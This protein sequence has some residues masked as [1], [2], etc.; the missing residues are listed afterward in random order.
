M[1]WGNQEHEKLYPM[2]PFSFV[3][4]EALGASAP[5]RCVR[6]RN[7]ADCKK[8]EVIE[9]ISI[10]EEAEQYLIEESVKYMVS[11]KV[12]EA[13]LPFIKSP[14]EQLEGQLQQSL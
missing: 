9:R 3:E 14:E 5:Y 7:C 2:N 4:S 11:K 1:G 6:C 13:L 10:R 8:G 12:L